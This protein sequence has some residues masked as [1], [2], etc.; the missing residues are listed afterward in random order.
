MTF[1]ARAQRCCCTIHVKP[2]S[3]SEVGV[4]SVIIYFLV[5]VQCTLL[6]CRDVTIKTM[7]TSP[8]LLGACA[9]RALLGTSVGKLCSTGEGTEHPELM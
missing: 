1:R 8:V 2:D 3:N 5:D 9:K 7:Q 6:L 4:F